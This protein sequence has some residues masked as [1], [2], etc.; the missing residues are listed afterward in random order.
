MPQW[1]NFFIAGA[2][3][4]GT[5]SLHAWLPL[6]PGV[7]M[8]RI[9]EPNYFSRSVI[10]AD[11]PMVQPIRSERA[12]LRLFRDAG[13]ARIVGEATPFYLADP[14]APLQIK[15]KCPDAKVLVTLRDPVER[16]YSHY[17]MMRNNL[18]GLG[19][20]MEEIARGLRHQGNRN[21]AILDP[22]LGLYGRQIERYRR[23]F[24][25]RDFK[26]IV[27]EKWSGDAA[28]TLRRIAEFLGLE[29]V[30]TGHPAPVQRRYAE[31]RGPLVR[32]VFGNRKL[33]RAT[34]SLIPFRLRKLIRG[35][36]LVKQAAKPPMDPQAR[37][38]L[39]RY[40]Q[41]DVRMTEQL[42]GQPLPWLNFRFAERA[43]RVG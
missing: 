11:H 10:G 9:K 19:E 13:D 6:L 12:Y 22:S 32:F 27:L 42:L 30:V 14:E 38:F 3:R 23:V 34:E 41:D 25:E 20:F 43:R 8:S 1:P 40:Y 28:R 31:A 26:V 35:K 21:L 37:E 29:P 15:R 36:F 39:I 7:F 17:L 2:P 4:C 16:L 24:G 18:G 33:S 5:T